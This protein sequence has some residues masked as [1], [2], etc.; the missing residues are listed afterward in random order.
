V[1]PVACTLPIIHTLQP[2]ILNE[3]KDL[4]VKRFSELL[5]MTMNGL[6]ITAD[7]R[8]IMVLDVL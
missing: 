7:H 4:F 5:R 8:R 2:V 1:L 3:V 6:R